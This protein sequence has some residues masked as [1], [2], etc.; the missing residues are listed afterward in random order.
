MKR[1]S[2]ALLAVAVAFLF[3]VLGG[4]LLCL[5][6]ENLQKARASEAW[7]RTKG[8]ILRVDYERTSHGRRTSNA[9]VVEYRYTV[10]GKTHVS[11]VRSFGDDMD[12]NDIFRKYKAAEDAIVFYDP[13]NP[14]QA[15][16]VPGVGTWTIVGLQFSWMIFGFGFAYLLVVSIRIA[17]RRRIQ[18]GLERT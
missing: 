15:T 2:S 8:I 12:A 7:L 5:H 3:I 1:Q 9:P 4:A 11:R 6:Y 14:S 17:L 16:L 10:N 13:A 18:L